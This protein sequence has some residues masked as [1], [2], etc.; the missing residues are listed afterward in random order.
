MSAVSF[1]EK[2]H[3]T[4]GKIAVRPYTEK[5]SMNM[6]LEKYA[7]TLFETIFHEEP[8]MCLEHNG[9][10]RYVTGLNEFAPEVTLIK[11]AEAKA[12]VIKR[13]RETVS[14]L[15]IQL[16]SNPID[17]SDEDFWKKVK[18]LHPTNSEF[19]DKIKIRVSNDPLFLDPA[20]DPM[21][22]VMVTAI[23]AGGF[24]IVAKNLEDARMRA[25]PVKFYLD[26]HED[27]I[28]VQTSLKKL[29]NKALGEL[30]K[31]FSKNFNKLFLVCKLV[32]INSAAYKK[33]TPTDVFYDNMD[34]YINGESHERNKEKAAKHFLEI[35][36]LDMDTLKI[37]AIVKDAG[38]YK[39]IG[40][41]G[42]G[43]IYHLKTATNLGKNPTEVAE[44]LKNPLNESILGELTKAVEKYWNQ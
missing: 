44:S 7:M 22:L 13:I 19:W 29:R 15:E 18:L 14:F 36:D 11:D 5:Q 16:A 34:R 1:I 8:L 38:Y 6:G 23:E 2:Y 32:D 37:R 20:N 35:Q 43:H 17:V 30:D 41:R 33:S 3:K 42:D 21:D 12:A 31:M 27:T 28:S 39:E 10:R 24:A 26:R 40:T 9:V 25:V 4:S